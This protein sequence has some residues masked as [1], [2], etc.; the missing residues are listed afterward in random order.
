MSLFASYRALGTPE[1]ARQMP[2]VF[3]LRL[4]EDL[5]DHRTL[6][7][8]AYGRMK[9]ADADT[10]LGFTQYYFDSLEEVLPK[11]STSSADF[12]KKRVL[13][14]RAAA[15]TV[16]SV[17]DKFLGTFLATF[18]LNV[19][20][21]QGRRERNLTFARAMDLLGN[22]F[23]HDKE[24]IDYGWAQGKSHKQVLRNRKDLEILGAHPV[25]KDAA[26]RVFRS[27]GF[28]RWID[29][30]RHLILST[31]LTLRAKGLLTK[32]LV[33]RRNVRFSGHPY[34][35]LNA[36]AWCGES[37][38]WSKMYPYLNFRRCSSVR[39]AKVVRINRAALSD[40]P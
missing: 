22:W 29:V 36:R 38:L 16:V 5:V 21:V 24:W 33:T 10:N 9:A 35:L 6:A 14:A 31:E 30:E 27:F 26:S 17:A 39:G 8:E 23:R 25:N 1:L 40:P 12:E 28:E 3:L 2:D 32:R 18:A 15:L 11:Y 13:D 20:D 7:S 19:S 4:W 34:A 37:D